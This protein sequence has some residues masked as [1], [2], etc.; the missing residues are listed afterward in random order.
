MPIKYAKSTT[1]Q[2]N[3]VRTKFN[4]LAVTSLTCIDPDRATLVHGSRSGARNARVT[5]FSGRHTRAESYPGLGHSLP[6][7]LFSAFANESVGLVH[8]VEKGGRRLHGRTR[9]QGEEDSRLG[10]QASR[11]QTL[12]RHGSARG[13][14]LVQKFARQK[15]KLAGTIRGSC[16]V[17]KGQY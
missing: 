5:A 1:T 11:R 17:I 9:E 13:T 8:A 6:P 3:S 12:R 16:F 2:G 15:S 10:Q 7:E 14:R 4:D